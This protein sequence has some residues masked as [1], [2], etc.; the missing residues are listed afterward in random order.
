M[1]DA[2]AANIGGEREAVVATGAMGEAVATSWLRSGKVAFIEA[3]MLLGSVTAQT[4]LALATSGSSAGLAD[5]ITAAIASGARELVIGV[6]EVG[7]HDG[8]QGLLRRLAK[9]EPLTPMPEVIA[10]ARG[11]LQG[12]D[13]LVAAGTDLPLVGLNGAGAA[14]AR[15][16]GIDHAGAQRIEQELASTISDVDAAVVAPPSLLQ[17]Q[18]DQRRASR[19]RYGGAGGGVA[20]ALAALG[21]RL[22]PAAEVVASYSDLASAVA[23]SDVILTV[24]DLLDGEAISEGVPGVVAKVA[25]TSMVPVVAVGA[26]VLVTRRELSGTAIAGTYALLDPVPARS[27]DVVPD[28]GQALAARASRV[29][30]TW[31]R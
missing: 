23:N 2:I 24:T 31:S 28:L 29:A 10:R 15:R 1:I 30:R 13:V 3:G 18:A 20:F 25:M 22:M 21:A 12:A 9:A 6:P 4:A 11:A 27:A 17:A 5:L 16:P 26:T 8:G 19:R 14:L 7:S